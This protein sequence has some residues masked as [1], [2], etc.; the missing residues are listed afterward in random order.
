MDNDQQSTNISQS[1]AKSL[2]RDLASALENV[3]SLKKK[4]MRL[5]YMQRVLMGMH[6]LMKLKRKH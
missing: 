2:E 5:A 6:F 4:L 3:A 1:Y